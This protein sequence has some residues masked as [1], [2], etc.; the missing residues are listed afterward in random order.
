MS[1]ELSKENGVVEGWLNDEIINFYLYN[2]VNKDK[3]YC[4][5]LFFYT[6]LTKNNAFE[7]FLKWTCKKRNGVWENVINIFE[8]Q[9]VIVPLH[10][11]NHWT[12][13]IFEPIK[14]IIHYFDSFINKTSEVSKLKV[15]NVVKPFIKYLQ[16][17]VSDK[18]FQYDL[19]ELK[20]KIVEEN[21]TQLNSVDCVIYDIV[22]Y[23]IFR[24]KIIQIG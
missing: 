4:F 19:K 2:F 17:E 18:C 8:K 6:K 1:K 20:V 21:T 5:N 16:R 7:T 10:L 9:Y 23:F 15:S 24:R 12:V 22:Y 11:F 3:V 14:K 13:I